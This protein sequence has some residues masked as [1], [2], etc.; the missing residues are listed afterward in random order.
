MSAGIAEGVAEQIAALDL[1]PGRPLIICDADEVL[2][3]FIEG[4]ER[5][6]ATQGLFLDLTS[7]ALTGNIKRR[8]DGVA[9]DAAA[10]KGVLA[11]FFAVET[12]L[13][14]PAPGA[15]EALATL[16]R[17]AQIVVL[18]NLPAERRAARAE[19]LT[20]H[21]MPYPVIANAGAKGPA[22]SALAA[23]AGRPV[24][25]LD[26]LPPHH[27]SVADHAEAVIRVHMIADRR[28]AALMGPAPA[29]HARHDDWAEAHAFIAA[30]LDG[31]A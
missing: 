3:L 5:H 1:D 24:V 8:A 20:R 26:D 12:A 7:F 22:V 28:L 21:G 9:L 25:F 4:L 27:A 31:A 17:R 11:G 19:A 14:D 13:L 6:L 2:F 15:A 29:A 16:S 18:S 30:T 10:V 23:R